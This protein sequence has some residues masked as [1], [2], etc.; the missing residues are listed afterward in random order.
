M[1]EKNLKRVVFI[2]G[3][4]ASGKSAAALLLAQRIGGEIVNADAIQVYRDLRIVSARPMVSEEAMAP[5]HLYGHVDGAERYSAGRWARDAARA[6][7]EIHGRG[8]AAIVCGGAGLYFRA[9]EFGLSSAP[10]VPAEIVEAAEARWT[11]MGAD[12]FRDALL[13]VDPQMARLAP[14]DRQRHIRAWAV[15]QASGAPLSEI[16]TQKGAPGVERVDARVVIAPPR[17][18]LYQ[19]IEARYDEMVSAGAPGEAAALA[20]RSLDP[21]LPVMKAVGAAELLAA[22]RGEIDAAEAIA[23]AKRNTRRFAKRQMT[24][25]R[26]QAADWPRAATTQAAVTIVIKQLEEGDG[27]N[28]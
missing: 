16:Q 11:A 8:R 18:A 19:R 14:A 20:A 2:A 1:P 15:F 3:P 7:A 26:N 27:C 9:L 4:T 22:E 23:L 21:R 5:H 24:W 28:L 13:A 25:F 17:E 10:S 6:I 12:K